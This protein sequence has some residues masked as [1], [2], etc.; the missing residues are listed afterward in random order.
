VQVFSNIF[1]YIDRLIAIVRPRTLIY[2][3]ID[4]VAPRAKMN[5]QRSRRF[6]AAQD[7]EEQKEIERQL[8]EDFAKQGIH[9]PEKAGGDTFDSNVITP[10]TPFM[11]R[12]AMVLQ[13]C[14]LQHC[15]MFREFTTASTGL[16]GLCA[17]DEIPQNIADWHLE[18]CSPG[19]RCG[20][21]RNCTVCRYVHKRLNESPGW[22][23]VS[24]ILSDANTPGEGEHKFMQFIREQ[25]ARPGWNAN[26][27]HCV[28]GLDADLIHL[29]L[30]SH[31]PHFYILREVVFQQKP[32][33][34]QRRPDMMN[35]E[36]FSARGARGGAGESTGDGGALTKPEVAK[37]P[38]QFLKI[39]LLREYLAV[40]FQDLHLP[41]GFDGERVIDDFVFLCFF[42]GNDFLPHM[43]TLDIR[44]QG[45]ELMLHVYRE[46]L[47]QLS[48]YLCSGA[49]LEKCAPEVTVQVGDCYTVSFSGQPYIVRAVCCPACGGQWL[50]I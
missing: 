27:W 15:F 17:G 31:E 22:R 7:R 37:K 8:R 4:G 1:D 12:L 16:S 50:V 3:A 35:Q 42:V 10:G 38:Y 41:F 9:V 49:Q 36:S 18:M 13:W 43:P 28:Y 39:N 46:Q 2:M 20:R 33:G 40:E 25:R 45:I 30:A 29:A 14:A 34:G 21:T 32:R 47:P 24:V 19:L 11:E 6:R 44:E 48:G 26:T 23:N 5:Q